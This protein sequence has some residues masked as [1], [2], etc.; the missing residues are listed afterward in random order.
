M[1]SVKTVNFAVAR[2]VLYRAGD[3][4]AL[5]SGTPGIIERVEEQVNG[6]GSVTWF[7]VVRTAE[8]T[9]RRSL[10]SIKAR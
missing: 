7:A 4:V 5:A 6:S 2:S 1:T 8:G 3:R 9:V 10:N